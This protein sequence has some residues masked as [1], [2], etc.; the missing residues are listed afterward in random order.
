MASFSVENE[1][2]FLAGFLVRSSMIWS[3]ECERAS[4]RHRNITTTTEKKNKIRG[5]KSGILFK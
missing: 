1:V 5:E 4:Q 2:F 3:K